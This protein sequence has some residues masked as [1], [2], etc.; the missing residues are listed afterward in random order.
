MKRHQVLGLALVASLALSL[1]VATYA[2]SKGE[3]RMQTTTTT[4]VGKSEMGTPSTSK[5]EVKTLKQTQ[6]TSS[7]VMP[8]ETLTQETKYS[9]EAQ[10]AYLKGQQALVEKR[11]PEAIEAFEQALALEPE[12][13]VALEG[14]GQ[15]YFARGEYEQ[16]LAQIEKAS[17]INP[18]YSQLVL[19][20]AKILDAQKKEGGALEGYL[21]FLS[22][23]PYDS[24]RLDIQRRASELYDKWATRMD[25]NQKTYFNGLRALA[26]DN[27]EQ[28]A[29]DLK[30]FIDKNQQINEQVINAHRLLGIAYQ[31]LNRP[32]EAIAVWEVI[33]KQQP[34]NA[35][36]YFHL[37]NA[38]QQAGE[39]QQAQAAW[40][41]FVKNAPKTQA[42]EIER[43][44][45]QEQAT[46]VSK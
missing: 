13:T 23:N 19:D 24:A 35:V 5:T 25:V 32:T 9:S 3:T 43:F 33:T 45:M 7:K 36:P 27:P 2:A 20:R 41:N 40:S 46:P 28:A 22:L 17:T 8:N 18:L 37:S 21:T 6:L 39:K 29:L 15:T 4:T 10:A 30:T 16:A 1:P 26:M 34:E 38:Y 31:E 11:F 12:Y 44:Y 14:L 42:Y